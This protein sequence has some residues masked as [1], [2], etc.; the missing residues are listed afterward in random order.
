MKTMESAV[1]ADAG[2]DG[3][4]AV[5]FHLN[6]PSFGE[7]GFAMAARNTIDPGQLAISVPTRFL[8]PARMR[9]MFSFGE[10]TRAVKILK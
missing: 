1:N 8:N 5:P 6:I 7:W 4:V 3:L 10:D 2:L 9:A